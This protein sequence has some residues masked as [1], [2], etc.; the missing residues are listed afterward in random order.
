MPVS[1]LPFRR[2]DGARL[3]ELDRLISL[4]PARRRR[5]L[6]PIKHGKRHTYKLG[7]RCEFSTKAQRDYCR[8]WYRDAKIST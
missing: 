5:R 8:Q 2:Y 4:M 6:K 7:C 1:M 3:R